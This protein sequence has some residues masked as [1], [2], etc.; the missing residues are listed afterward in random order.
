MAANA[1]WG[2]E[3][4]G[5]GLLVVKFGT[6]MLSVASV[7]TVASDAPAPSALNETADPLRVPARIDR[8]TMPLLVRM[9]AANTVSRASVS[10]DPAPAIISVMISATS[11]TVTA[12]AS[13]SDP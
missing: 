13:T 3:K 7:A 1:S 2:G 12:T 8:P 10:A 4:T 6:T 9:T 11:I 5:P